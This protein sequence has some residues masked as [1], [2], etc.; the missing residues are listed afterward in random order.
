MAQTSSAQEIRQ[1]YRRIALASHPDKVRAQ[2]RDKAT[3]KFQEIQLAY[4]V[5]QDPARRSAYDYETFA[6]PANVATPPRQTTFPSGTFGNG[7]FGAHGKQ[8]GWTW[9]RDMPPSPESPGQRWRPDSWYANF[10]SGRQEG[11]I[12]GEYAGGEEDEEFSRRDEERYRRE[13]AEGQYTEGRSGGHRNTGRDNNW[14]FV[15]FLDATLLFRPE[16]RRQIWLCNDEDD[17]ACYGPQ[18]LTKI[19]YVSLQEYL[20]NPAFLSARI[21]MQEVV[22]VTIFRYRYLE[23]RTK[24][25]EIRR[26]P[27]KLKPFISPVAAT[28]DLYDEGNEAP[29]LSSPPGTPLLRGYQQRLSLVPTDESQLFGENYEGQFVPHGDSMYDVEVRHSVYK[30]DLRIVKKM[31]SFEIDVPSLAGT[32]VTA[33]FKKRCRRGN[34][35]TVLR[36]QGMWIHNYGGQ[37]GD[38]YV[39]MIVK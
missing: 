5:L 10:R 30:D 19:L 25:V 36:G 37:R 28:I 6:P 3:R 27:V 7:A 15:T 17:P 8:P 20:T 16:D 4:D 26:L 34:Y 29:P 24:V 1:A 11:D 13:R 38:L 12:A 33:R 22:E 18:H 39:D 32:N 31:F 35:E 2:D 21:F 9:P 23:D 14:K